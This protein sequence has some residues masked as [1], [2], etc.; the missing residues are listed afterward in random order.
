MRVPNRK[1]NL[2]LERFSLLKERAMRATE[3]RPAESRVDR[4]KRIERDRKH[5]QHFV[6]DY[7]PHYATAACG[8]FHIAA[9]KL[10]LKYKLIRFLAMWARAHA[11]STHFNIMIPMWLMVQQ[12]IELHVMVLVG[13]NEKNART[14]LS[15]LQAELESNQF[16]IEDF[17]EQMQ[18]GSWEDGWFVTKNDC[19]FY[20]LGRGQSPRGLRHR[21]FRPDYIVMDDVDDDEL[22]RNPDRVNKMYDWA[23][24]A[25]LMSSDM[26][27]CRFIVVGNK[28]GKDSLVSRFETNP[29]FRVMQVNAL[30]KKGDPEWPEKYKRQDIEGMIKTLG[31]RSAQKELFH[32]PITEGSVFKNEWLRVKEPLSFAKY[33]YIVSYCDPS[34]KN[35]ATSD[36]K[37]II[38]VGK[39]AEEFHILHTFVRKCSVVELVRHWY[40]FHEGLHG[41]AIVDYFMEAN[42][43]QDM[44][45]DE[46]V[47]EGAIRGYQLPLRKDQRKKP[48]KFARIE[49]ISPYFENGFVFLNRDIKDTEDTRVFIDQ[50]LSF[51]KGSHAHDD[52]PDALEGSIYILNQRTRRSGVGIRN[53][54]YTFSNNRR[55]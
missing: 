37:A 9:S 28:I 13:K 30:N 40:D 23:K 29:D 35:S 48:D 31:Y 18:Q 6:S 49:A 19:A 1:D 25:L 45:M 8:W 47:R 17:G 33:Q 44:I 3:N 11:K 54:K 41:K 12:P 22:C 14:L 43:I 53:G 36:Y 2:A 15:D 42:F 4:E 7:F 52:A 46:F 16:Y 39:T 27:K 10:I 55:I 51:E 21:Q 20:A 34:F 24:E 32:N 26:G 50:L 38:T 5:Y